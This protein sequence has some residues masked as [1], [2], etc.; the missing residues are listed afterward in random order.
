MR[1]TFFNSWGIPHKSVFN[2]GPLSLPCFPYVNETSAAKGRVTVIFRNLVCVALALW[3]AWKNTYHSEGGQTV[4]KTN[5]QGQSSH[6][7]PDW[8]LRSLHTQKASEDSERLKKKTCYDSNVCLKRWCP[9]E[10]SVLL[11]DAGLHTCYTLTSFL[12]FEQIWNN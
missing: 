4:H 12:N 5:W 1:C 9:F 10:W 6:T 2:N 8:Q 7:L 11:M 3:E